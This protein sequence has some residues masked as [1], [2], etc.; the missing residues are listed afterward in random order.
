[1]AKCNAFI[2]S[3]IKNIRLFGKVKCLPSQKNKGTRGE[4]RIEAI[5]RQI[6][7]GA[8]KTRAALEDMSGAA[9]RKWCIPI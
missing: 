6:P 9:I 3:N 7:A 5:C 4:N 8:G 2:P 1:M